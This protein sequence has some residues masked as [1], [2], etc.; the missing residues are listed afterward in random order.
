[1]LPKGAT[2]LDFAFLI[3][4]EVGQHTVG[5][6]VNGELV[7]LRYPLKNGDMV[8]IIT[9]GQAQP[10]EDWLQVLRTAGARGKVRHWLRQRRLSDSIDLGK[11]MLERELKRMR[12]KVGDEKLLELARGFGCQDLDQMYGRLA[13]GQL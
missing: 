4:T 13:E 10:H 12:L 8:E 1:R 7:P 11:E 6:R 5:A 2:A 3:H 9:S